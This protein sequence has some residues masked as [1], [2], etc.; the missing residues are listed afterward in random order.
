LTG[1][2]S[3]ILSCMNMRNSFLGLLGL[4]A[5]SF[6]TSSM[7]QG[8]YKWEDENGQ[9]HYSDM[10]REG[11]VRI[12][13]APVQTFDSGLDGRTSRNSSRKSGNKAESAASYDSLQVS[14]PS[15]EETIWNTGGA[16]NVKMSLSPR[17][18]TGHSLNLYLDGRQLENLQGTS[19]QL[20]AVARGTHS[21]RAEVRDSTN[22]V[23]IQSDQ[24]T[25]Y[26]KQQTAENALRAVPTVPAKNVKPQRSQQ[27]K[28]RPAPR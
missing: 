23:V 8:V 3:S 24:V 19:A 2:P 16:I 28:P 22:K 20:S 5:L 25:F 13:I 1:R 12:D 21:L 6:A 4:V 7:A 27:N 9:L 14:S 26:V 10:P 11:A 15:N 18:Q 17:L